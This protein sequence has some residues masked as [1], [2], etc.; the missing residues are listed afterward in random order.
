ML[1][2]AAPALA[3]IT[4]SQ[5]ASASANNS[6]A[7]TASVHAVPAF[8]Q[9]TDVTAPKKDSAAVPAPTPQE[10]TSQDHLQRDVSPNLAVPTSQIPIQASVKIVHNQE[11]TRKLF[12][13]ADRITMM[14]NSETLGVGIY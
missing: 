7:V 6:Q 5:A 1:F 9:P 12:D 4:K 10:L 8:P 11:S 14:I 13:K 2:A 3:V